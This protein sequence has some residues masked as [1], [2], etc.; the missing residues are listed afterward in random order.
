VRRFNLGLI[1]GIL[2]FGLLV[3]A[4]SSQPTDTVSHGGAVEDYDSL[5]DNLRAQ[6]IAVEPAG[7]VEQPFFAPDGQVVRADDQEIQVF[8]FTSVEEAESAAKTI[9]QDGSSVGTSMMMWVGPPHFYK[10]DKIIILYVGADEEITSIL[11]EVLG[12]QIA[13]K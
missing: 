2:F 4:C 10:A 13:G 9:S 5:V 7:T 8:E 3:E 12:P 1:F 6:G 11:E